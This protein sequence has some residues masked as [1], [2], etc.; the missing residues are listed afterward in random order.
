MKKT[1]S[2]SLLFPI[3]VASSLEGASVLASDAG[4]YDYLGYSVSV[5]G[6]IGFVGS[7]GD[8][9]STVADRGSAYVFRGLDTLAGTDV[10]QNA[11]VTASDG[12]AGDFFGFAVSVSGTIGLAGAYGDDISAVPNRGSAYVFRGLDTVSG[13]TESAKL[14]A[15]DGAA[16]NFFGSAVSVSGT[17]GLVGAYGNVT[18]SGTT[19]S[20]A[21]YVFRNLDT[22]TGTVQEN[23]KLVPSSGATDDF[24]GAAVSLSGTM[25]LVGAYGRNIAKGPGNA[26]SQGAAYLYRGLDTVTGTQSFDAVLIASD[27]DV[28]DFFG[29]AVGLSGNRA[30]VGAYGD[31]IGTNSNQGSAYLYRGL[32]TANNGVNEVAKLTASDGA[33]NDFFGHAVAISGSVG[34]VGAYGDDLS[35]GSVY[36]FTGL[37]AVTGTITQNVKITAQS[38]GIENFFGRA[39]SLD[40]DVFLIG[41]PNS[42]SINKAIDGGVAFSGS[43]GSITTLDVGGA[44]RTINGINFESWDDW[45]IGKTT[46]SNSVTLLGSHTANVSKT[47]KAVYI[48][49]D[50]G[51]DGN[52]LVV[53]GTLTA[54][55]IY[56]GAVGNA[57]NELRIGSGGAG[58]VLSTG[59]TI[60]NHGTVVFNRSGTITQGTNFGTAGISGSGSV[61]KQGTGTL[62]F[63]TAHGYT[64]KTTI[65]GGTLTLAAN[66]S[67][68]ESSSIQVGTGATFNVSAV[69]GGWTLGASQVL[70]G[71]GGVTGAATLAGTHE[72]GNEGIGKQLFSSNLSY[73]AGSVFA[74]ELSPDFVGDGVGTR[75]V[76]YDAVNVGGTLGGTGGVF[77][78]V[79]QSGGYGDEFWNVPRSWTNVFTNTTETTPLAYG[80]IFSGGIEYWVGDTNVT[81]SMGEYGSFSISGSSLN[82]VAI[83]EPSAVLVGLLLVV[84]FVRRRRGV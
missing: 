68:A 23:V 9:F 27:G 41:S 82:W 37:D 59:S 24:F 2:L 57:N 8:D 48:G 65:S 15:S 10:R 34:I 56:V 21:A 6:S 66:G 11:K 55:D 60:T 53:I 50:A 79:L 40:G 84:G 54:T 38:R 61:V 78:V 19:N 3:A 74:W 7:Y 76:N 83:P 30:L 77:K 32:A 33:A 1:F 47:G 45:I 49:K 29:F 39:V 35:R 52:S 69:T 72:V 31:D 64:G 20:G 22:V 16:N 4:S 13:A 81:S 12:V 75:G 67:I 18:V 73:S 17:I 14:T 58:G 71:T 46:D 70:A 28:D 51:S 43:V 26:P 44:S 62:T 25:G 80:G 36:L 42:G 5:S 63:N